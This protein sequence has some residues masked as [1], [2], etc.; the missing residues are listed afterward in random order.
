MRKLQFA[1]VVAAGAVVSSAASAADLGGYKDTPYVSVPSWAGLYFGGHVGGAW[2]NANT[3]DHYDY[4]GDPESKNSFGLNGLIAG[5]QAGYNIQRGHAVFGLE[6]DIGYLG[7]SGSKSAALTPSPDCS[8][9]YEAAICKIDGKY[10]ASGD[11]YGDLTA[12]LGYATG[13]SLFYV[14]GGVAF[15]DA[16][17]KADYTGGNCTTA[18]G[19]TPGQKGGNCWQRN[20]SMYESSTFSFDHS[21]TA[22]GWTI[23]AGAEYA[24]S[25][26]WSLKAEYQHFDFGSMSYAYNGT[27]TIKGTCE[28][29]NQGK[30]C[31]QSTLSDGKNTVWLGADAVS[32]GLNYHVGG[33]DNL[34]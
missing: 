18:A 10:S 31:Y 25:P 1:L 5:G 24:L 3:T 22:V 13:R 12:R 4:V 19:N 21:D 32:V 26:S 28:G 30:S 34:K 33:A 7:I 27:Y 14:K 8:T 16:D 29:S 23:G 20:K 17:I 11:L 15:L 6:G 2:G 9:H